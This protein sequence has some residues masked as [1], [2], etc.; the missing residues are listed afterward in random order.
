MPCWRV[1]TPAT[2]PAVLGAALLATFVGGVCRVYLGLHWSSDLLAGWAAGMAFTCVAWLVARKLQQLG[3]V[4]L[5]GE[6]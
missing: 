4:E 6:R 1:D 5:P 3:I 2:A